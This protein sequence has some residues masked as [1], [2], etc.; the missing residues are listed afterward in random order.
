MATKLVGR[1][2]VSGLLSAFVLSGGPPEAR[3]DAAAEASCEAR[4]LRGLAGEPTMTA[5]VRPPSAE[6]AKNQL[7]DLDEVGVT[8]LI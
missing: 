4:I 1:S 5:S 7:L 2:C 3:P 8:D 6:V